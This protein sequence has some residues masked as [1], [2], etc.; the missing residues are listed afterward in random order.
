MN[1]NKKNP[2][3]I[4]LKEIMKFYLVVTYSHSHVYGTIGSQMI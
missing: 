1:L 4:L 3:I 2:L